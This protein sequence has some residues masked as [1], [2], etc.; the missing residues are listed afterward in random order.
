M[1]IQ[2]KLILIYHDVLILNLLLTTIIQPLFRVFI[3]IMIFH[4][5]YTSKNILII[6]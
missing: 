3:I 5:F 6:I 4:R 1:W 2:G